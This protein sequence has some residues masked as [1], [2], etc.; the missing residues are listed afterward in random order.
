MT[1]RKLAYISKDQDPVVLD[2]NE[3]LRRACQTM[4][5][6]RVGSVLVTDAEQKLCG[7]FTGRDAVA[8][9]G[10][11]RD[12]EKTR[13]DDVMTPRPVTL[14]SDNR[15]LDAMNAMAGCGCR[16]V[17]I[18]DN[19]KISGIVSRGDFVG[20][21]FEEFDW[22]AFHEATNTKRYRQV[23]SI[24]EGQTPLVRAVTDTVQDACRA[25]RERRSG[26]VL[27]VDGQ[28]RLRGIFTGRDAVLLLAQVADAAQAPLQI[29]MKADPRTIS[30]RA[31]AIDA[32]RM[33]SDGGFRHLPVVENGRI[34][35]VVARSDFT[36]VELDRLDEEL[37]L[38]ECIW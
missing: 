5:E 11:G 8:A 17:P 32:L 16:H 4:S 7:I 36:G 12:G 27:V 34:L 19:G 25:M 22:D 33:M 3:T 1:N 14:Q 15:A 24:V 29:A 30:P 9:L 23:A 18:V 20:M 28:G 21:E 13:L 31:T 26:S 38:A 6:R 2:R 10:A 37:H 35:G